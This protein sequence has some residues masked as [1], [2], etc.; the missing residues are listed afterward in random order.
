[1]VAILNTYFS[2]SSTRT[3]TFTSGRKNTGRLHL[4]Q[5]RGLERGKGLQGDS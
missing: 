3:C 4:V 2:K 1:M 5:E